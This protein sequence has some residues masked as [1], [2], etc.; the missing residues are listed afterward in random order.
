MNTPIL[1]TDRLM[2]RPL[3]QEDAK[4]VLSAGKVIQMLQNICFGQVTMI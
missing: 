2:L 1:E 4:D 3:R